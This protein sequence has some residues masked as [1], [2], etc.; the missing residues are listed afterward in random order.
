MTF[1]GIF[2]Q[3]GFEKTFSSD[4]CYILTKENSQYVV[5]KDMGIQCIDL[6]TFEDK[7]LESLNYLLAGTDDVKDEF[8]LVYSIPKKD[9]IN[10]LFGM[11]PY[12]CNI[13]EL[14]GGS[15]WDDL[16]MIHADSSLP[17]ALLYN[18]NNKCC[19]AI[20]FSESHYKLL[21]KQQDCGLFIESGKEELI[22]AF[23]PYELSCLFPVLESEKYAFMILPLAVS[24]N[25]ISSIFSKDFKN[26]DFLCTNSEEYYSALKIVVTYLNLLL[27]D[28]IILSRTGS[29]VYLDFILDEDEEILPYIQISA[30]MQKNLREIYL[31]DSESDSF[32]TKKINNPG[33]KILSVPFLVNMP[34]LDIV[35]NC[36]ISEYKLPFKF[37]R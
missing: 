14:P 28:R 36:L 17:A 20:V 16:L 10:Y 6:M 21:F 3:R 27:K 24:S 15:Y 13:Y 26:F 31:H 2:E 4:F 29:D 8:N 32:R 37:I 7:D 22:F 34:E 35:I 18:K 1:R 19:N 5:Y 9:L 25:Y 30:F 23:N 12:D 33:S 11:I